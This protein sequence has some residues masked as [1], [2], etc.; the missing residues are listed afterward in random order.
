M[1]KF[2]KGDKVRI[3][4]DF[5]KN[6][7]NDTYQKETL[8]ISD[9]MK[10]IIIDRTPM[11]VQGYDPRGYVNMTSDEWLWEEYW[12]ELVEEEKEKQ[13]Q[14]NLYT[15]HFVDNTSLDIWAEDF[16]NGEFINRYNRTN[17]I[18]IAYQT[19]KYIEKIATSID[20]NQIKDW[21]YTKNSVKCECEVSKETPHDTFMKNPQA[22]TYTQVQGMDIEKIERF[23]GKINKD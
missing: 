5:S 8:F 1:A 23:L 2:K 17:I 20:E 21:D 13:K 18:H 9:R 14:Y 16:Q 10:S 12:L 4:D 11:I 19:I 7:S 22:Y 6:Y 3:T 15:V